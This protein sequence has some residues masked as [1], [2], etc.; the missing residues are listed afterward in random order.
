LVEGGIG[1]LLGRDTVRWELLLE[2]VG[3]SIELR[4]VLVDE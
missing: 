2:L 1:W 4:L 3:V